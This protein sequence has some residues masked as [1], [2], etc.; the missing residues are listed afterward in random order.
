MYP[1]TIKTALIYDVP[2]SML[3]SDTKEFYH[4]QV[5]CLGPYHF[6][7]KKKEKWIKKRYGEKVL[8]M[9]SLKSNV[10]TYVH[11]KIKNGSESRN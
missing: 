10:A 9:E 7:G 5:L 2:D 4:R 6:T 8:Q 1:P 3:S 11:R